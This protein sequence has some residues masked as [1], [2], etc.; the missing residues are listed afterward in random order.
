VH[1]AN[2]FAFRF[3]EAHQ[4]IQKLELAQA[5]FVDEL[6]LQWSDIRT[7]EKQLAERVK[8]SR[9]SDGRKSEIQLAAAGQLGGYSAW[10]NLTP[11]DHDALD[12]WMEKQADRLAAEV[13]I[14]ERRVAEGVRAS[15]DDGLTYE[16]DSESETLGD[17]AKVGLEQGL[18]T[19]WTLHARKLPGGTEQMRYTHFPTGFSFESPFDRSDPRHPENLKVYEH[20]LK[21]ELLGVLGIKQQV[22]AQKRRDVPTVDEFEGSYTRGYFRETGDGSRKSLS[23]PAVRQY[24]NTV[25]PQRINVAVLS[26]ISASFWFSLAHLCLRTSVFP[27]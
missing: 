2:R 23:F 19:Y 16:F 4:A 10:A 15:V 13:A 21:T 6:A 26:V 11:E 1:N 25:S 3:A 20:L 12:V 24:H 7:T 14:Q 5:R 18:R 9:W 17:W 8:A 22:N 27:G